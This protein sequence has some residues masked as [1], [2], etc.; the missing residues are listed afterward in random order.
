M[1]LGLKDG[2]PQGCHQTNHRNLPTRVPVSQGSRLD[3]LI[4]LHL[5][6]DW[7]NLDSS[8]R[9]LEVILLRIIF[10]IRNCLMGNRKGR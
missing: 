3:R 7:E 1:M 2:G 8:I 5:S 4:P 10:K 9:K 6:S